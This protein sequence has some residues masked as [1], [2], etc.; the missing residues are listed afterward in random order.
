MLISLIITLNPARLHRCLVSRGAKLTSFLQ[1]M[2]L[3]LFLRLT[4]DYLVKPVKIRS[5][6]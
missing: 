1:E 5:H 6:R 4:L 2:L 3:T